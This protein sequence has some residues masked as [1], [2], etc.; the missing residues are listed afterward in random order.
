[1][2]VSTCVPANTTSSKHPSG[3]G[4]VASCAAVRAQEVVRAAELVTS[5]ELGAF[6]KVA[7]GLVGCA[8][9]LAAD[10]GIRARGC[11]GHRGCTSTDGPSLGAVAQASA[12][13]YARSTTFSVYKVRTPLDSVKT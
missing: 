9:P 2:S 8:V 6:D 12:A 11:G 4:G 10:L 7:L 3:G 13:K 1:M 5:A